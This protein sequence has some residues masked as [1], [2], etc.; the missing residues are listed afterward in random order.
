MKIEFE[1]E[2]YKKLTG[3]I[4]KFLLSTNY[5]KFVKLSGITFPI[6]KCRTPEEDYET[7]ENFYQEIDKFLNNFFNKKDEVIKV[8]SYRIY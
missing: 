5:D 7:Q 3:R 2:V 8:T 6:I 1:G 4:N